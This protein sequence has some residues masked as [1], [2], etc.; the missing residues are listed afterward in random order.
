MRFLVLLLLCFSAQCATLRYWIGPCAKPESGCHSGDAEL[1]QWA[2]EAWQAAS[3]GKLTFEKID[4]LEK[5]HI[6]LHWV[7]SRRGAYGETR[8]IVVDG[9]RGAEVYVQPAAVPPN[10]T[11]VLLRDASC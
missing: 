5:A 2:M 7:T 11:D 3:N 10:E 6:R 9:V 8:P 1:A 4:E